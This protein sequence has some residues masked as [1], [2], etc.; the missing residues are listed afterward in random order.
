MKVLVIGSQKEGRIIQGKVRIGQEVVLRHN[1]KV[2]VGIIV[3]TK[4]YTKTQV[5]FDEAAV[6]LK[7]STTRARGP[8]SRGVPA[9]YGAL[10][11]RLI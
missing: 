5:S 6:M 1:G 10:S 8:I 7:G 3:R 4:R 9:E 11:N 2:E